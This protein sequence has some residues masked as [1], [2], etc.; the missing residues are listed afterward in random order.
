MA[1]HL[2]RMMLVTPLILLFNFS[3]VAQDNPT[4]YKIFDSEGAE[5]SFS[6]LAADAADHQVVLFGEH[7][8]NPIHHWLQLELAKALFSVEDHELVLGFEMFESDNQLILDEYLAGQI[9]TN[10]FESQARLWNNYET[11]Y[12]PIVEFARENLVSVVATNIPRRY[13]SAVYS[14]GLEA[15]S[16]LSAGGLEY[17]APLPIEIDLELPGYKH[18]SEAAHGHGGENLPK[19]QAVKD[20]TM[21][22][23]TLVNL[24]ESGTF[25]HFNGAYHSDNYEGIYWYLNHYY[26]GL[27]IMTI[28]VHEAEDMASLEEADFTRN[29]YTIVTPA[30]MVKTY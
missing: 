16:K 30:S 29:D 9:S 23:F 17:I 26:E 22:Y 21:A 8:N 3:A 12:K 25:L 13:A 1:C 19:S 20:A 14:G 27:S 2:L 10:S 11:D 4:A 15:L 18:I 28:G 7:H 24:P 6:K 5:V